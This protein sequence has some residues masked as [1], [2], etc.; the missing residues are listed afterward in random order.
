M[1]DYLSLEGKK[2]GGYSIKCTVPGMVLNGKIH[3][4]EE[5]VGEQTDRNRLDLCKS[6]QS[7]PRTTIQLTL[8]VYLLQTFFQ[9]EGVDNIKQQSSM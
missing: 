2:N 7:I 1:L 5:E 6:L 3:S 9:V 8:L 4:P